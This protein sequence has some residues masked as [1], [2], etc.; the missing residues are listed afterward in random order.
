MLLLELLPGMRVP[1]RWRTAISP[2]APSAAGARVLMC[3]TT[4]LLQVRPCPECGALLASTWAF[5]ARPAQHCS[6]SPTLHPGL[7]FDV[8]FN[9]LCFLQVYWRGCVDLLVG[10]GA[11]Q[12]AIKSPW[13]LLHVRAQGVPSTGLLGGGRLA[14][15]AQMFFANNHDQEFIECW[16]LGGGPLFSSPPARARGR[17]CQSEST[18]LRS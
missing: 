16:V 14:V 4:Q 15:S 3:E 5:T 6:H 11:A 7:K 12:A 8:H 1:V 13:E 17:V 2:T 18:G 9:S 10:P